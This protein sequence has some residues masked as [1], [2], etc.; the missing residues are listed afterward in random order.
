[1]EVRFSHFGPPFERREITHERRRFA[2]FLAA[3]DERSRNNLK[4]SNIDSWERLESCTEDDLL[5]ITHLGLASLGI[6]Q[7][8]M[9][10]F[11]KALRELGVARDAS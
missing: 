5:S 3:L 11:G 1:M 2:D 9:S 10:N 7:A 8:E 6:I 4:R